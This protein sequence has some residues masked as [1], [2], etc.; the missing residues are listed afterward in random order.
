V[1][2]GMMI[3]TTLV[4]VIYS[5]W[6]MRRKD[7]DPLCHSLPSPPLGDI[8]FC[9]SGLTLTLRVDVDAAPFLSRCRCLD[10][11]A[12]GPFCRRQRSPGASAAP[13]QRQRGPPP[14]DFR[15]DETEN[16]RLE[17][18]R[19]TESLKTMFLLAI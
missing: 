6:L 5:A 9:G 15:C 18:Q 7:T 4:R 17:F 10:R 3:L 1:T 8:F 11:R 12:G 2:V 13:L 16:Y 14:A 19:L